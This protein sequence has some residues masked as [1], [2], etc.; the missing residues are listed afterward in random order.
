MLRSFFALFLV[1]ILAPTFAVAKSADAP[2]NLMDQEA[3]VALKLDRHIMKASHKE[4]TRK[5]GT[6]PKAVDTCTFTPPPGDPSPS[7]AVTTGT[8]SSR[9]HTIKPSCFEKSASGGEFTAC[10]ATVGNAVVSYVLMAKPS[11]G[12]AMKNAF[13][14]QIGRLVKR[15]GG[16]VPRETSAK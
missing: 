4:V 10:T 11:H 5:N 13:P 8:A 1:S 9:I 16:S 6:P 15:L 14:D 12:G 3:L 7:V 2:C